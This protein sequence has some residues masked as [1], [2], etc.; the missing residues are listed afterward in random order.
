MAILT[1]GLQARGPAPLVSS[2][3][4]TGSADPLDAR[5]GL[6]QLVDGVGLLDALLLEALAHVPVAM[7][8]LA[9]AI[10]T[11]DL[12]ARGPALR[13]ARRPRAT[14]RQSAAPAG[15]AASAGWRRRPAPCPPRP[16]TPQSTTSFTLSMVYLSMAKSSATSTSSA[17]ARSAASSLQAGFSRTKLQCSSGALPSPSLLG[18]KLTHAHSSFCPSAQIPA[19]RRRSLLR[20]HWKPPRAL[21]PNPT[22]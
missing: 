16:T 11:T 6:E 21:N 8:I 7:A 15:S 18:R 13:A 19:S 22:R 1:T 12:Q 3:W 5:G 10:L 4:A 17:S 2:L 20:A 9:M 14:R